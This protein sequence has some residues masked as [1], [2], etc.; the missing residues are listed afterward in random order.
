MS[1]KSWT[2]NI[3]LFICIIVVFCFTAN[4]TN[5]V[6]QVDTSTISIMAVSDDYD[7]YLGYS[8]IEIEATEDINHLKDLIKQC[9][10]NMEITHQLAECARA[11]GYD[12][13]SILVITAVCEYRVN[14]KAMK[15]YQERLNTLLEKAKN[16]QKMIDY[17][18]ATQ[19][20]NYLKNEGLNDYVAAGIL[21]NM[22]NECGGL[23]LDLQGTIYDSSG[24]FYGLCQ[25]SRTWCSEV[26]GEDVEGQCEYLINTMKYEFDTFGFCYQKSFDYDDFLG[27]N[28]ERDAALAFAKCYERCASG[29][30]WYRQECATTA[31]NYFTK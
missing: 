17:P 2:S 13:D 18:T 7:D 30:Y 15:I 26:F 11:L 8:E 14:D 31:Y 21:G 19:V 6:E 10:T 9:E 4:A 27:M 1:K 5:Y 12:D 3:I 29:S 23:T 25:W 20:W 22:M 24:W 28:N 16:S